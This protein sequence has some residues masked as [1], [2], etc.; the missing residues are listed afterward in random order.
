MHCI[1]QTTSSLYV[2][3]NDATQHQNSLSQTSQHP[4]GERQSGRD[5]TSAPKF[6]AS[7]QSTAN[8]TGVL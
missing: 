4:K 2:K 5:Q 1:G 3:G 8:A 6:P 7:V